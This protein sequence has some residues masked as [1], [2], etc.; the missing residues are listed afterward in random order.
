MTGGRAGDGGGTI[1]APGCECPAVGL[2]DGIRTW[3]GFGTTTSAAPSTPM[4]I[5]TPPGSCSARLRMFRSQP[6]RTGV[7]PARH[8]LPGRRGRIRQFIDIGPACPAQ[9]NVH[10]IAHKHAPDARRNCGWS[11]DDHSTRAGTSAGLAE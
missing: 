2:E 8:R 6:W 5:V 11:L 4:S 9:G 1:P 3:P 10:Q 7:S